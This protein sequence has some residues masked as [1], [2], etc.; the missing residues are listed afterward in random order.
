M[1]KLIYSGIMSLDG[2]VAD[3]NGNFDWA[4]PD[5]EVHAF[6][7]D[8]ERPIGTYLLGRRMY[9]VMVAWESIEDEQP[10]IKDYAEIWRAADKV[11]YSRSMEK[12]SSARTRLERTFDPDAIREMKA[13]AER[14]IGVG[15][16]ELAA[17]AIRAGLVDEIHLYVS[18]IVV[19]GGTKALPDEVRVELELL[20]EHR[21]RDGIVY[22]RYGTKN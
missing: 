6:V 18:P 14:D 17:Q 7:N 10:S 1:A 3:E 11:V 22:L 4:E 20:A 21:F 15:G 12:V 13:A 9:D 2:Y 19:G 8:I 16:P 5:E